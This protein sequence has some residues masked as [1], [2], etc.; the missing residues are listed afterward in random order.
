MRTSTSARSAPELR[1][2]RAAKIAAGLL[3]LERYIGWPALQRGLSL[4]V[5][6]YRGRSM[7]ADDFARTIGDAADRDLSWFFDPLF[8]STATWDYAVTSIA[9]EA[10]PGTNCGSGI[11]RAIDGR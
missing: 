11:V 1:A 6:R 3:T 7:S 8:K 2:A 4:A 9:T 10:R 5:E